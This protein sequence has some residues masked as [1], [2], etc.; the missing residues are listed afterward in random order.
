MMTT[1]ALPAPR[2]RA[3]PATALIGA[4]L[5]LLVAA[6]A[7]LTPLLLPMDPQRAVGDPLTRPTPGFWLG[8]NA[9]GQ[10]LF[11]QLIYGAQTSLVVGLSAAALS[12]ILSALAGIAAGSLGKGRGVALTVIDVLLAVPSMPLAV[13][14]IATLGPG[15]WSLIGILAL[16]SWAPFARIVRMQVTATWGRDYVEA[17]RALGASEAR[18][19]RSAIVPEIA[20]ILLT[21]FLLTARWAILMEATLGLLGLADPSRVSWGLIL[22]QALTYPLLFVTDAWAWWA[23]PPAIGIVATTLGL[24]AAGRE[25]ESR[26]NPSAR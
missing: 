21:K 17:A 3:L 12:M 25:V 6:T 23:A 10:D 4:A 22:H 15:F 19:L 2:P 26:L 13:L 8:T 11:S 9:L 16:L 5:L 7:T 24:M 20:P 18:V 1:A 14:L